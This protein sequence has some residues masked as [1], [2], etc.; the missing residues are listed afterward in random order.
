MNHKYHRTIFRNFPPARWDKL[1]QH[2]VLLLLAFLTVFAC[3]ASSFADNWPQWR[4]PTLDGICHETD[5]PIL[6]GPRTN[7]AWQL[8]M[9]GPA[10]ATPVIWEDHLFLTAA[11]EDRLV[12]MAV[13]TDGNRLWKRDL[14]GGNRPIRNDEANLASPSPCTDG[15]HVW[16]LMGNGVLGCYDFAG[17]QVWQYSLE[18]RF[19]EIDIAFGITSTPVLHDDRLYLQLIHTNGAW[20]IALDKHTGEV[21]W[22]QDRPSD[23]IEECLHSYASP[24]LYEDGERS[25]LISH[26]ADYVVAHDLQDGSEL[27]RCGGMNPR[28]NYNPT[29]RFVASPVP[30]SGLIVVPSAKNGPV[31]ALDPQAQGDITES[32]EYRLWTRTDNTPDVPSP[33]VVDDLV[34]LCRENGD[35]LCLDADT[36]QEIYRERTERDR[37]RAS[38]LY[39]DGHVYLSARNGTVTVVKTGREFE[40][41]SQNRLPGPLTACP[42]VSN[43]HLYLRTFSTLY[44]IAEP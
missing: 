33:L 17:R 18:D 24:T 22:R 7:I 13:S 35:L 23:A 8:E 9:P 21:V 3:A 16:S 27:W 28:G 20:I 37:H 29:L 10:G 39:A 41:V 5:I 14:G 25:F 34:Y 19:G 4:G 38:P 6:W 26:G 43:G 1:N 30:T 44:C 12:L 11:E 40:I 36:G 32:R 15:T 42:A 2:R 31:L